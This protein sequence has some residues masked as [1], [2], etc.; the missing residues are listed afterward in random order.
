MDYLNYT[1]KMSY[2]LE[3]IEKGWAVNLEDIARKVDVTPRTA[4]RIVKTLKESGHDIYF[5][6]SQKKYLLKK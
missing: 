5:S 3:L 4:R 6:Q 1:K 2:V